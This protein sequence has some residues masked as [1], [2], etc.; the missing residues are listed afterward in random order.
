MP[1]FTYKAVDAQGRNVIGR[2]EAVNLFDLEQRLVR[3]G[4]DLVSGAPSSQRSRLKKSHQIAR[5]AVPIMGP[6]NANMR[7]QGLATIWVIP[8]AAMRHCKGA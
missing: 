5:M 3:M 4:L 8:T 1:L 6:M 2:A 7:T